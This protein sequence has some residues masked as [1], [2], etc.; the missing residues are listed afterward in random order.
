MAQ[1]RDSFPGQ[2]AK[3]PGQVE[4]R[5]SPM[6]LAVINVGRKAGLKAFGSGGKIP[7]RANFENVP[8][9]EKQTMKISGA[10]IA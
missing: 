1:F 7:A 2:S 5:K 10:K 3:P 8:E 4:S 6:L 9:T